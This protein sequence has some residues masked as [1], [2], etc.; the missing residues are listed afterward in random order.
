[1]K[2]I[3]KPTPRDE[4]LEALLRK[5]AEHVMTPEEGREQRISWVY[6][7]IAIENPNITKEQVRK[8]VEENYP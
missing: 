2:R 1:M 4:E 5:T 3:S 6:G 7:Q 8:W